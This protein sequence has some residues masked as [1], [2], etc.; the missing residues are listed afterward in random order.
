MNT[1]VDLFEVHTATAARVAPPPVAFRPRLPTLV[2]NFELRAAD[3]F[4]EVDVDEWAEGWEMPEPEPCQVV[5]EAT[6]R[7]IGVESWRRARCWGDEEPT[8]RRHHR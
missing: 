6:P 7:G 8:R 5:E 1:L 3:A 4:D 2:D